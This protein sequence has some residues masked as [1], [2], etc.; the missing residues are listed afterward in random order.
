MC[1]YK[2]VMTYKVKVGQSVVCILLVE[3]HCVNVIFQRKWYEDYEP[4][5]L[6]DQCVGFSGWVN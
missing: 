4:L 6:K 2:T 3:I 1:A 5:F